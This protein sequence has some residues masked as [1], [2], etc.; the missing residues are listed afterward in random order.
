MASRDYYES[1]Q[2]TPEAEPE[3]IEAAFKRLAF[4][5]HPDRNFEG[6]GKMRE[7]NEAY[8]TLRDPQRRQEYDAQRSANHTVQQMGQYVNDKLDQGLSPDEVIKHLIQMGIDLE[9]SASIVGLV[10]DSRRTSAATGSVQTNQASILSNWWS[11]EWGWIILVIIGGLCGYYRGCG[12]WNPGIVHPTLP[13]VVAGQQPN[14]WLPDSGYS[15]VNNERIDLGVKWSPGM[16]LP[17]HPNVIASDAEG[18]WKPDDG[19]IWLTDNPEGMKRS[20]WR[21]KWSPGKPSTLHSKVVAGDTERDWKPGDGYV[22]L[23]DNLKG[24]KRSDWHVKWSPGMPSSIYPNI[25]AGEDENNW[26]PASGFSWE[27]KMPGNFKVVQQP[28]IEGIKLGLGKGVFSRDLSLHNESS[29][30]LLEVHLTV[31]L[32]RDNGKKETLTKYWS[33]WK[34]GE[35]KMV[36]VNAYAYQKETLNGSALRGSE[37]VVIRGTWTIE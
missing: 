24:I 2:V 34:R 15:W 3:V 11:F 4:K 37:F 14:T 6:D 17:N 32:Y 19:Y 25:I 21:V 12:N 29:E 7:L 13:N 9:M 35:I 8:E 31:T 23:T 36:G 20:D 30:D 22:W 18:M 27:N 5:Y 26:K 33:S 16:P 28:I 1:L 10:V